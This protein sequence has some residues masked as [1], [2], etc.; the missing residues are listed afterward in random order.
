LVSELSGRGN[1]S[2]KAAE[3]GLDLDGGREQAQA[4]VEEI[5]DLEAQGY[6]FE[7]AEASF[8]LLL[9]RSQPGYQ[10]PFEL[11]AFYANTQRRNGDAAWSEASVKVKVGEE[12]FHTAAEGNGPVNA[13]DA[14]MRK[15]LLNFYPQLSDIA[16]ADYKVRVLE[17]THGTA[18]RVRVLIE[19]EKADGTSWT[20]VGSS[21]NIIEASCR[22]LTDSLEFALGEPRPS[23]VS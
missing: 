1:V 10:A 3:Y 11:I 15:A 9:R 7:G 21:E 12:V 4:V 23:Q 8:Q 19:S 17:G 5:K 14:A 6:Q 2:Y 20:T 16:L 22:A 13:L 18:A